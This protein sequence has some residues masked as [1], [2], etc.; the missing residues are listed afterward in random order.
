MP[1]FTP[2]QRAAIER[3]GQ[4]VCVLAGPGSGKTRVLTE[5]FAWLV[6]DQG[7]SA[8][9]VLAV[10]FTEKAARE[11]RDRVAKQLPGIE[12]PN[13]G[14]MHSM[15]TRI[16][17]EF[18]IAAGLDPATEL[19]DQRDARIVLAESASAV[20][21]RAAREE[22]GEFRR[23][24]ASWNS[25][26]LVQDL[27][28]LHERIM[29]YSGEVPAF[30]AP[31]DVTGDLDRWR[32]W[33][34]RIALIEGSTDA[35]RKAFGQ[36]RKWHGDHEGSFRTPSWDLVDA[37][38]SVP[39]FGNLPAALKTE[40]R[41]L[42]D[43]AAAL[44]PD[45][46]S[47]LTR[48]EGRYIVELLQ[49]TSEE[50]QHR[51]AAAARLDF[52]DL[53][54]TTAALLE[55]RADIRQDLQRRFEHILMDEMQDTSPIQWRIVN[56]L[57]TP[58]T[59]FA[60]G[61]RNQSI[62]SFRF[63]APELFEQYRAS[64]A[65]QGV[66]DQ[67]TAN[68][69]SRAEILTFTEAICAGLPGIHPPGLVARREFS[70]R[71]RAVSVHGFE[72]FAAE[73]AFLVAE[74]QAILAAGGF[75][76]K[77]IAILVRNA[78]HGEQVAAALGEAGLPFTLGGGK[79]FFAAQEV[80]D[81]LSYLR[82][83]ANTRDEV[84]RAA[85][86]RSP[87]V[88]LRDDGLIANETPISFQQRLARHRSCGDAICP[89]RWLAEAY[90]ESG[91]SSRLFPAG[92][93]NV[94]KL[95]RLVREEWTREPLS[96]AAFVA[97]M[98]LLES[99]ADEKTAPVG[100][101]AAAIQILTAH[102]SK[103][104]EFPVVFLA[105]ASFSKRPNRE[106]LRFHPEIGIGVGWTN[107]R[108]GKVLRDRAGV[109]IEERSSAEDEEELN[110]LLYVGLTR[111]EQRLYVTWGA[112]TIRGWSSAFRNTVAL[113]DEDAPAYLVSAQSGPATD[114]PARTL[115]PMEQGLPQISSATP[116]EL[117]TFTQCPRRYLL[118]GLVAYDKTESRAK[119]LGNSVHALL[120]G[121]EVPN[122]AANTMAEAVQ[123]ASTFT[124]SALGRQAATATIAEREF[125]FAF[126][127]DDL[128]IH[129][130]IDLWFDDGEEIVIVD[131]KTDATAGNP[132]RYATQL[133]VYR[134]ALA[135]LAPGRRI[136]SY[137][138]F[139]R[140][141][142]VVECDAPLDRDMLRRF[143][144]AQGYPVNPAKHCRRCPHVGGACEVQPEP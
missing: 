123:L 119:E 49:R 25:Q 46:V 66:V 138:H 75:G 22:P 84:A 109:A 115:S 88:G 106:S 103:G 133:A 61:D 50:Y 6:R 57:R 63:A 54:H 125:D 92:R 102:S 129:G 83:V 20:L 2:E 105:R 130:V 26:N 117:A 64:V 116:S 121:L 10:T 87:F 104:L 101:S 27:C 65:A 132:E 16:V 24:L 86:L 111:A 13:I 3:T 127:I 131:Y 141:D 14:T 35:S 144:Y 30:Q 43:L 114:M 76:L 136:R 85:V 113:G 7:V 60:V 44:I 34:T 8:R 68:F 55:H 120:A 37:L 96:V 100:E 134:E 97:R 73:A 79:R 90:D 31:R 126:A 40:T 70:S 32:S 39:K 18:S 99:I 53:E 23:L 36:F 139:L 1:D 142:E 11:I 42:H 124:N 80:I 108:S 5:R 89:D 112:K 110:R 56:Q 140:T 21:N 118:D 15:C 94:E 33:T 47:H 59:F 98:E 58:G 95:L 12:T 4:D 48:Q 62:F 51:K 71:L 41:G 67:L 128:V 74:I 29:G 143:Q 19:W 72:G 91:Y 135:R 9:S 137:L 69:R 17:R 122:A 77:D 28:G 107:P 45:V 52:Q 93:A 38:S 78:D 81:G 82:C